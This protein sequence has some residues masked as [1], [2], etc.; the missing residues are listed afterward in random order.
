M[1]PIWMLRACNL[2]M[3]KLL[4]G[5]DRLVYGWMDSLVYTQGFSD[6]ARWMRNID[7]E[8]SAEYRLG[9]P[10]IIPSGESI[11]PEDRQ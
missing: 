5:S 9:E 2:D 6:G 10:Q 8:N 7:M 1:P 4:R 3:Q 11:K